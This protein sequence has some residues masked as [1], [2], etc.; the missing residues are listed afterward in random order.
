MW[1]RQSVWCCGGLDSILQ[2]VDERILRALSAKES[3][4]DMLDL[5][6]NQLKREFV[7]RFGAAAFADSKDAVTLRLRQA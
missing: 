5:T 7:G 2:A 3:E 1:I 6:Y 4:S